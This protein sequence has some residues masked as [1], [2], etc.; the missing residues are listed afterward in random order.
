MQALYGLSGSIG[1]GALAAGAAASGTVTVTGAAVGHAVVVVPNTDPGVGFCIQ[2]FV[3]S[4]NTVTV[5]V[6][7]IVAGTPT[8]ST[9]VVFVLI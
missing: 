4:A 1:G 9:Y 8:A 5:R 2:A 7:A 6:I 3:T